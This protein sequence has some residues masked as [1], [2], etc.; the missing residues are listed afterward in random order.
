MGKE[1]YPSGKCEYCGKIFLRPHKFKTEAEAFHVYGCRLIGIKNAIIN[2]EEFDSEEIIDELKK[3]SKISSL[4]ARK[5][6]RY[7]KRIDE[8]DRLIKLI[9]SKKTN[10]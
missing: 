1:K 10:V 6:N 8:C 7:W 5:G 9:T 4:G 3:I 2:K